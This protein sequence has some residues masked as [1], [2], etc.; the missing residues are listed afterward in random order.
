MDGNHIVKIIIKCLRFFP[1]QKGPYNSLH[2]YI[3]V[4]GKVITQ[5]ILGLIPYHPSQT[6]SS[7][8]G[9]LREVSIGIYSRDQDFIG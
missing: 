8:I 1:I 3:A 2:E 6:Q 5:N 4:N 9:F 7:C